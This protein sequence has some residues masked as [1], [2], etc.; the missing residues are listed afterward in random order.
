MGVSKSN[1][2]KERSQK[3][4]SH[5]EPA[6][7]PQAPGLHGRKSQHQRQELPEM[8][9]PWLVAP[10]QAPLGIPSVD[11]NNMISDAQVSIWKSIKGL[12]FTT[13]PFLGFREMENLALAVDIPSDPDDFRDR[14]MDMIA[15]ILNSACYWSQ[16][17]RYHSACV[18]KL[19]FYA[20]LRQEFYNR[21]LYWLEQRKHKKQADKVITCLKA[22]ARLEVEVFMK[23]VEAC[24]QARWSFLGNRMFAVNHPSN[25]RNA[26]ENVDQ[27]ASLLS[28]QMKSSFV[29]DSAEHSTA[30]AG[31]SGAQKHTEDRDLGLLHTKTDQDQTMTMTDEQG[32]V[33]KMSVDA[34]PAEVRSEVT[35]PVTLASLFSLLASRT[36]LAS[37]H[38]TDRESPEPLLI[39]AVT[40]WVRLVDRQERRKKAQTAIW[41]KAYGKPAVDL[42]AAQ[43]QNERDPED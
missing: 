12:N 27:I 28:D 24:M 4:V 25:V 13:L 1:K 22:V 11:Y 18:S 40:C 41:A 2:A 34:S 7:R 35:L 17:H 38:P 3:A 15:N 8:P 21:N 14:V 33:G 36:T 9:D 30:A 31:Q 10:T 32:V 5:P 37:G 23:V 19:S 6:Q 43:Q 29:L 39:S 20:D 26:D 16:R 42:S